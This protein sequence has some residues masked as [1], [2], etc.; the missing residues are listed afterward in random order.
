VKGQREGGREG[1][2]EERERERAPNSFC[3]EAGVPWGNVIEWEGSGLE[4]NEDPELLLVL[5]VK[6]NVPLH[7]WP[8]V[9]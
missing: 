5:L 8:A 4:S 6:P 1:G 3:A 2:G 9:R 7:G